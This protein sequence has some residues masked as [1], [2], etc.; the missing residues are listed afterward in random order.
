[1]GLEPRLLVHPFWALA[2]AE[3][4]WRDDCRALAKMLVEVARYAFQKQTPF[5]ALKSAGFSSES[6]ADRHLWC[7]KKEQ[8]RVCV[9]A[10]RPGPGRLAYLRLPCASHFVKECCN[11]CFAHRCFV[12]HLLRPL[13]CT[14][15][16]C[17]TFVATSV[18]R[19]CFCQTSVAKIVSHTRVLSST[20]CVIFVRSCF[21]KQVLQQLF[22]QVC[23]DK[24]LSRQTLRRKQSSLGFCLVEMS[25]PAKLYEHIQLK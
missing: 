13:F 3:L 15:A 14:V 8:L 6:L 17:Q 22:S 21:V 23:V 1:M 11:N 19:S 25:Q 5:P 12:K 24:Q 4:P 18:L 9:A 2:S 7:A 10:S 16:F 20:C